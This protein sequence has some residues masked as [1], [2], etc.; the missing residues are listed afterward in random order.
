MKPVIRV[1]SDDDAPLIA[2][3]TRD[4][5]AGTVQPGSGGHVETAA[6]V[7]LHLQRGGAF[8]LLLDQQPIGSVRWAPHDA[9]DQ[10][11][12][13]FRLGV[14]PSW[15]GH[16]LSQILLEAVIHEAQDSGVQE[17][18]LAVPPDQPRLID[19]Y[20]AYQFELAGELEYSPA[21]PLDPTALVMR[22]VLR[23]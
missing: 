2:R 14:L 12:E 8:L 11:W 23:Q 10:T 17:L 22:R 15:R 9:E 7:S 16:H 3:L 5:W 19:R 6:E 1:A 21:N 18:R 20:A 13:I 4:A